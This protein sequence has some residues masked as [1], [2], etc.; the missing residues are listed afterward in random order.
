MQLEVGGESGEGW[1]EI[2]SKYRDVDMSMRYFPPKEGERSVATG[3]A[4]GIIDC[5]AEKAAAYFFDYCSRLRM[6]ISLEEGNPA[7]L[8]VEDNAALNEATVATVKSMP[9]LLNDREF[10][11]KYV[12]KADSSLLFILLK[13]LES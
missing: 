12:W 10:V 6:R 4:D 8:I 1:S 2:K 5:S 7:R 3:R 11:V 9:F 13:L